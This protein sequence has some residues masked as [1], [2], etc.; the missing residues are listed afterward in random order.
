[1]LMNIG[2]VS[3]RHASEAAQHCTLPS[4]GAASRFQFGPFCGGQLSCRDIIGISDALFLRSRG[5]LVQCEGFQGS[6]RPS[7]PA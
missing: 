2:A 1:M 4:T 6:T 5:I 3:V 7:A